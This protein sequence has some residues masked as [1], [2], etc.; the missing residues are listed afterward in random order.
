MLSSASPDLPP[1]FPLID[2]LWT[3]SELGRGFTAGAA[4][5]PTPVEA[6]GTN[7]AR[8]DKH[9]SAFSANMLMR[10]HYSDFQTN[11][12]SVVEHYYPY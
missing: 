11:P 1:D 6:M 5:A 2:F 9:M 10:T 12:V 7:T 3:R 4:A 8:F